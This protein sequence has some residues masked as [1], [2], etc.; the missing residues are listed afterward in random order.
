MGLHEIT[1]VKYEISCLAYS[2]HL[3]VIQTVIIPSLK[4]K[5]NP[6]LSGIVFGFYAYW[7][8]GGMWVAPKALV[9]PG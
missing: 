6:P 4:K 2:R 5:K 7:G 1:R 3:A 9:T 8:R